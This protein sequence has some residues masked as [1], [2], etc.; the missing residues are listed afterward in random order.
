MVLLQHPDGKT[1]LVRGD[2]DAWAGLDPRWRRAELEERLPAVLPR[3]RRQHLWRA[4]CPRGVRRR[5]IPEIVERVLKVYERGRQWALANPDGLAG[6]PGQ[7]RQA[8][9]AGG[10]RS[11]W[12]APTSSTR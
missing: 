3:P 6:D 9:R 8:D 4:Q 10:R 2:V 12:S 1:A 5:S 7:G 11:S